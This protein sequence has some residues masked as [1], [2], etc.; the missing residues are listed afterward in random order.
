MTELLVL[1]PLAALLAAHL[2]DSPAA[3]RGWW[4]DRHLRLAGVPSLEDYYAGQQQLNW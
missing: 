4:L 2:I 3:L 1:A